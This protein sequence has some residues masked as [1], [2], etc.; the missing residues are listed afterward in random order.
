MQPVAETE[1]TLVILSALSGISAVRFSLM[2][3]PQQNWDSDD[4][5]D[6]G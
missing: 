1:V 3:I 5:T 4:E 2:F 6:Q